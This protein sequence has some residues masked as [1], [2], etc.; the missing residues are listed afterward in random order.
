MSCHDS[1]TVRSMSCHDSAT[2]RSMSCHDSAT[3]RSMSCHDSATEKKM[4]DGKNTT[5]VY[6]QQTSCRVC[7]VPAA[8]H[9]L[10]IFWQKESQ[11]LRFG[12]G[13]RSL[14]S[15]SPSNRGSSVRGEQE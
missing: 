12:P 2:V 6:Y 14:L 15:L 3:V 7:S 11:C 8:F 4:V 5:Q 10:F 9:Q 1:A 13:G